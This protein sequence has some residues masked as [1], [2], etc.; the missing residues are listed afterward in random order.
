MKKYRTYTAKKFKIWKKVLFFAIVAVVIFAFTMIL[1]NVLKSKLENAD[2]DTSEI[3]DTTD[4]KDDGDKN[5]EK[6]QGVA[7]EEALGGVRA[8]YLDLSGISDAKGA[9]KAVES[10][11][12]KG[13]NALSFIVNDGEGKLVY[14]SPAV[15]SASRLPASGELIPYDVLKNAVLKA[16][17]MDI[18]V[19]AVMTAS[20]SLSDGLVAAELSEMGV[21]E[22]IIRGFEDYTVLD[23][24]AVSEIKSYI[25]RIRKECGE[26]T[27]I[28]VCFAPEF[29]KAAKNAPYIEKIY[30]SAEFLSVDLTGLSADSVSSVCKELSGSFSAYLL[31]PLLEGDDEE[32]TKAV[33]EVLEGA[34]I[35]SRQYI[36]GPEK[37][38]DTDKKED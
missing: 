24:K 12:A 28:S 11:S 14:A 37:T 20:D 13:F 31:R 5:D 3:S 22:I 4:K 16:R 35:L 6:E 18:R 23:N 34:Q 38:D 26:N 27:V 1:G 17:G 29:F 19:S 33:N 32:K 25:E 2:I 21:S 30:L 8:G 15:E 7:H 36:S 9:Y 10:V